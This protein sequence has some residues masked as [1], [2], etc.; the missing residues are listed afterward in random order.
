MTG[1]RKKSSAVAR[2]ALPSV[3]GIGHGAL[4]EGETC[5]VCDGSGQIPHPDDPVSY[6]CDQCGGTGTFRPEQTNG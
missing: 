6:D 2:D 4:D 1:S 3:E 5:S